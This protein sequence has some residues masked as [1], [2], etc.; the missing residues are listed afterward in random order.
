MFRKSQPNFQHYVKKMT[1]RQK[2]VCLRKKLVFQKDLIRVTLIRRSTK[3]RRILNAEEVSYIYLPIGNR[4]YSNIIAINIIIFT[5]IFTLDTSISIIVTFCLIYL[6]S[7]SFSPNFE[8]MQ[9]LFPELEHIS[10]T[11]VD[12]PVLPIIVYIRD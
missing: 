6:F 8:D 2:T 12:I 1:L 5:I 9:I 11:E 7:G 3:Y 10:E 4:L